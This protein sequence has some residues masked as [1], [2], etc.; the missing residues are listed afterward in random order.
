MTHMS[1]FPPPTMF[2]PSESLLQN[3]FT[4]LS[5]DQLIAEEQERQ[6]DELPAPSVP[7]SAP[8]YLEMPGAIVR[9][10]GSY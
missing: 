1:F 8:H 3:V 10:M 2:I 9:M 5:A 4:G 7:V 6:N